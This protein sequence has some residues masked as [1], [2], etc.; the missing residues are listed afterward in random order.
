MHLGNSWEA[1]GHFLRLA[2]KSTIIS[3]ISMMSQRLLE[4]LHEATFFARR[5]EDQGEG[6]SHE[7]LSHEGLSHEGLSHEG[8]RCPGPAQSEVWDARAADVGEKEES[9]RSRR[10]GQFASSQR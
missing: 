8:I 5:V 10:D 3:L 6:L 1:S 9:G 4:Q 7:G 2:V